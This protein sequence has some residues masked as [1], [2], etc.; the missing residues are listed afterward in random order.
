[1]KLKVYTVKN[2]MQTKTTLELR[3]SH[4]EYQLSGTNYSGPCLKGHSLERNPLERTQF[5]GSKCNTCK[6][7]RYSLSKKD[8]SIISTELFGRRGVL[9]RGGKL[10]QKNKKKTHF[11][12]LNNRTSYKWR[13]P[14]TAVVPMCGLDRKVPTL[15]TKHHVCQFAQNTWSV[16]LQENNNKQATK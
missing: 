11:I 2:T 16:T 14:I 4:S 1:M 7:M 5:L 9:I 3:L 6:Y 8:T 12:S 10:Y 13:P 15:A